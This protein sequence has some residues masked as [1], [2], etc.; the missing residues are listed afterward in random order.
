[1]SHSAS[2]FTLFSGPA[3]SPPPRRCNDTYDEI[4]AG[5]V[6]DDELIGPTPEVGIGQVLATHAEEPQGASLY[7]GGGDRETDRHRGSGAVCE[8][9]SCFTLHCTVSHST[10]HIDQQSQL[11]PVVRMMRGRVFLPGT[12]A[13]WPRAGERVRPG[14]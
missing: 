4:L 12:P 2:P 6:L 9:E 5:H 8:D 1:M 7:I 13:V 3:S 11:L 10:P 14:T